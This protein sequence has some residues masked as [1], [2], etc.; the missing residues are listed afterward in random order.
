MAHPLTATNY[1][2]L[3][4]KFKIFHTTRFPLLLSDSDILFGIVYWQDYNGSTNIV[5]DK[6]LLYHC[7]EGMGHASAKLSPI[8]RLSLQHLCSY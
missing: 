6:S 1:V 5:L 4:E 8:G 3:S 2:T 7:R